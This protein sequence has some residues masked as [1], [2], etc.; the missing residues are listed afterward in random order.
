VR[1]PF[2]Q[3]L[4]ARAG[5]LGMTTDDVR[6]MVQ[7]AGLTVRRQTVSEDL[8][9]MRNAGLVV[10]RD[11]RW[12]L[13]QAEEPGPPTRGGDERTMLTPAGFGEE[14]TLM[15]PEGWEHGGADRAEGV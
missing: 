15:S 9:K 11:A 13:G 4:L 10:Q 5:E 6:G 14:K 1:Q 8:G 2:I 3:D 12:F 7:A